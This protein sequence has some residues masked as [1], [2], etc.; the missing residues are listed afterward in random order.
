MKKSR[1]SFRFAE[2]QMEDTSSTIHGFKSDQNHTS[3]SI[4]ATLKEIAYLYGGKTLNLFVF[5]RGVLIW[6]S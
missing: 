2:N 6:F 4:K 5:K 3:R 1:F